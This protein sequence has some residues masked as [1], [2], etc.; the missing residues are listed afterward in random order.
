MRRSLAAAIAGLIFVSPALGQYYQGAPQLAS[1]NFTQSSV[2]GTTTTANYVTM[3]LG[4]NGTLT[5][6][7]TGRVHVTITGDMFNTV[8]DGGHYTVYYGTG[9]AP[10]NA[11]TVASNCGTTTCTQVGPLTAFIAGTTASRNNF[12]LDVIITGETTGTAYWYDVGM[13]ATTGGTFTIENVNV[14]ISEF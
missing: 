4:T 2:T 7:A 12:T 14:A 5:P 3:G 8:A 11:H 13:E 9:S 10:A 1:A 6:L